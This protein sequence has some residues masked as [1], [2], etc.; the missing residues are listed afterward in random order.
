MAG[1]GDCTPFGDSLLVPRGACLDLGGNEIA[2][3]P[4]E[5]GKFS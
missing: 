2:A 4:V 3:L 5:R 1:I